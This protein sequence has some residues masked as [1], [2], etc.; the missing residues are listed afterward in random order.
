LFQKTCRKTACGIN[1]DRAASRWALVEDGG[2]EKPCQ[3]PG[4]SRS[5]T[6][7][8]CSLFPRLSMYC[9]NDD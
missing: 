9:M 5:G 7:K 1:P 4:D 8:I 2:I 3:P 6:A